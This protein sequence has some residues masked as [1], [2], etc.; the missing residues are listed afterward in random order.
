MAKGYVPPPE[1]RLVPAVAGWQ[2]D[3]GGTGFKATFEVQLDHVPMDGAPVPLLEFLAHPP[4]I[5]EKSAMPK[6]T[7]ETGPPGA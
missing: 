6:P 5:E 2:F 1:D 4:A 7:G 3:V